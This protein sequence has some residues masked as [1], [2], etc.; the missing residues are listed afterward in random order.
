MRYHHITYLLLPLLCLLFGCTQEGI[1]PEDDSASSDPRTLTFRAT[2]DNAVTRAMVEE[3]DGSLD[4][5]AKF[6]PRDKIFL[7]ISQADTTIFLTTK[8][9]DVG[10]DGKKCVFE[11]TLPDDIDITKPMTIIGYSGLQ[12][13][14]RYSTNL[15]YSF[16]MDKDQVYL[17]ATPINGNDLT[18]MRPPVSFCLKDWTVSEAK[19]SGLDVTF[20]HI[21][22]YEVIH[23]TNK[24]TKG[25]VA[26]RAEVCLTDV[27]SSFP[28]A[29]PWTY[30]SEVDRTT[31]KNM[32]PF[33]NLATGEVIM[34]PAGYSPKSIRSASIPVDGTGVYI[35]WFLP[36]PGATFGS[37]GLCYK[38]GV[39][40][41]GMVS[42]AS[43]SNDSPIE[44]GHAY[45]VYGDILDGGIVLKT[46]GGDEVQPKNPRITFTT[47]LKKGSKITLYTYF[48]FRER[49]NA[50]VDLNGNGI[51]DL[52]EGIDRAI[53]EYTKTVDSQTIT[54]YGKAQAIKLPESGITSIRLFDQSDLTQLDLTKN[55]LD[56][57]AL[58]Q[59]MK[60]LPDIHHVTPDF[61]NPKTLSIER[62]PG[63]DS[64]NPKIALDKDW[65]ID[66]PVIDE[67]QPYIYLWMANSTSD[68]YLNVDAAEADRENVWI[69][70][71]GNGVKDEGEK[72]TR[73]GMEQDKMVA[74]TATTSN[75]MLYGKVT[76]LS[77]PESGIFAVI[78]SNHTSLKYIDLSGNGL[79]AFFL[80]DMIDL[81][82]LNV[83]DNNFQLQA[84]PF[85]VGCYPKLKVLDMS[86]S[87]ISAVTGGF[88]ENTELVS[89]N[90]N[91]C[92][93]GKID[94][95]ANT[96]L[97][98]LLLSGN[99]LE[100]LS[101]G[102]LKDL[103]YLEVIGNNMKS[104]ALTQVI[105]DLCTVP[106][107][108]PGR[109]FVGGNP[110]SSGIDISPAMKKN[111]QVD[112]D[113]LKGDN[114]IFRPGF[115]GEK[116]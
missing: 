41:K 8:P 82:Y 96:K 16:V 100:E 1:R 27:T 24:G 19:L 53:G 95:T 113:H 90:A 67:T 64:C 63:E 79:V 105:S 93:L 110:G 69:D 61:V 5:S 77:A 114:Y 37:V 94:L 80:K 112:I 45:H 76:M 46:K 106:G 108:V 56:G 99:G 20:S 54:I 91:G 13:A 50:F 26:N 38:N 71:N 86:N 7:F 49:E 32:Y 17:E 33:L 65:I 115:K 73:F 12:D 74:L 107:N 21:G 57:K 88:G 84:I 47:T 72:I 85:L 68:I 97:Q 59:M 15:P 102:H 2:V 87:N 81:E 109:L 70:L 9:T 52:G 36:R 43:L 22:A 48:D 10:T 31:R 116:W 18:N 89:L 75:V 92:N 42:T 6:T 98:T 39:S 25:T 62:N 4:L 30:T 101:I 104:P 14:V 44:V 51:K 23:V 78:E 34:A 40:W 60:D 3:I 11:A 58:D 111:W 55:E 29:T 103:R 28:P 66:I 35:N 83:S